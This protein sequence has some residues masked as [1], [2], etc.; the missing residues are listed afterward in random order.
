MK[1]PDGV[2]SSQIGLRDL[3]AREIKDI[4]EKTVKIK[5]EPPPLSVREKVHPG[6]QALHL[7]GKAP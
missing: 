3:S 4:A 6:R 5:S 1:E 7:F 2:D